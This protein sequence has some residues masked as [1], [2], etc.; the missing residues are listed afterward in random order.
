MKAGIGGENEED[1][2]SVFFFVVRK[3][4]TLELV[5]MSAKKKK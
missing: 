2:K 1:G 5:T 4:T 3:A